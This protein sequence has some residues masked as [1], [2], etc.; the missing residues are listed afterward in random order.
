MK[1][2]VCCLDVFTG[3][4][5]NIAYSV[6][7]AALASTVTAPIT[8]AH[9]AVRNGNIAYERIL[10]TTN[11]NI[12]ELDMA[13]G[14]SRGLTSTTAS[15]L[16]PAWS[17]N[18]GTLAFSSN[19]EGDREIYVLNPDASI[20]RLTYRAGIDEGPT[21]S[22]D[23][24]YIAYRSYAAETSSY[25]IFYI[26]SGGGSPTNLSNSTGVTETMPEW[27]PVDSR[28]VYASNHDGD[29]EIYVLNGDGSI[30]Q[31]T[32][33]SYDDTGPNWS[34][35]GSMI[36]Y[37]SI[38]PGNNN[39]IFTVPSGG[40]TAVNITS[41]P[42]NEIAPKW[43]PDGSIVAFVYIAEGTLE[44]RTMKP[45]GS[46]TETVA[47]VLITTDFSWRPIKDI[48]PCASSPP[49]SSTSKLE[50]TRPRLSTSKRKR[51]SRGWLYKMLR[52]GGFKGTISGYAKLEGS[53]VR[54]RSKKTRKGK[55]IFICESLM[56]RRAKCGRP[57]AKGVKVEVPTSSGESSFAY[58]PLGYGAKLRRSL[59][60]LNRGRLLAR[61][62]YI[63]SLKATD[64]NGR[65]T[66]YEYRLR[67]V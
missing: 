28:I 22:P 21:W 52:T 6:V 49:F 33:N 2:M 57:S 26:P 39:E 46:G 19:R 16:D 31:L 11:H 66:T 29:Y 42:A 35:D 15:D 65:S 23:C 63:L 54:R 56:S 4:R 44:L 45:D 18:G 55:R 12:Y 38:L 60:K 9:A 34:P 20:T 25:D 32:D 48:D 43:A 50:L 10:S 1:A 67:V 5:E 27:S 62:G 47:S 58:R 24:R 30:T 53:L 36:A 13:T 64:A 40:G 51:V 41:S 3:A 37:R 59:T 61:G 8:P 17:P 14:T 7:L